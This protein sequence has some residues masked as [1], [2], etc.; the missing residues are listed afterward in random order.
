KVFSMKRIFRPSCDQ[1]ARSPNRVSR[2]MCGGRSR[3]GDL[4]DS[5]PP[6]G[7]VGADVQRIAATLGKDVCMFATAG[8]AG[9]MELS[10]AERRPPIGGGFRRRAAPARPRLDSLDR[11]PSGPSGG[12]ARVFDL[13]GS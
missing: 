8:L 12:L 4:T 9:W 13:R 7:P 6:A 5:W 1:S 3:S 11:R 2:L 10:Q